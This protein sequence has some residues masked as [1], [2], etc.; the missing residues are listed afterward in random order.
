MVSPSGEGYE[1]QRDALSHF[2]DHSGPDPGAGDDIGSFRTDEIE[3]TKEPECI[4]VCETDKDCQR[5]ISF[6][7]IHG[8]VHLVCAG[9]F[10]TDEQTE[11]MD[12]GD[13]ALRADGC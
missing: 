12:Q 8:N 2:H 6:D 10:A 1:P 9:R 4:S 13:A 7:K 5:G 3:C 11:D